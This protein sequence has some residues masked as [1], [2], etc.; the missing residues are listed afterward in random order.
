VLVGLNE[1]VEQLGVLA[2]E[3]TADLI[4]VLTA[5]SLKKTRSG[6]ALFYPAGPRDAAG[7]GA[8]HRLH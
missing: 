7:A 2:L 4:G 1:L 8:P 6:T 5:I 3:T